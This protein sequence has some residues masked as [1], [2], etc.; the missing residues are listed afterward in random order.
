MFVPVVC[1]HDPGPDVAGA[2][3]Q[4]APW[5]EEQVACGVPRGLRDGS[6]GLAG[7]QTG[8]RSSRCRRPIGRSRKRHAPS[9]ARSPLVCCEVYSAGPAHLN[10]RLSMPGSS[11]CWSRATVRSSANCR[12]SDAPWAKW[13]LCS[14]PSPEPASVR[15]TTFN[16]LRARRTF[17]S[18]ELISVLAGVAILGRRNVAIL[19]RMFTVS[20]RRGTA[21][22]PSRTPRTLRRGAYDGSPRRFPTWAQQCTGHPTSS[23]SCA[24]VSPTTNSRSR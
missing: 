4:G 18:G 10:T 21:R 12:A 8:R 15:C 9:D 24:S 22:H 7:I 2:V 17:M 23:L 19:V 14:T 6:G 5:F 13:S 11:P 20:P 16:P 3:L 1:G